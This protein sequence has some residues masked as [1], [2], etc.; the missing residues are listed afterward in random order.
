MRNPLYITLVLILLM[1]SSATSA[2][3]MIAQMK[4]EMKESTI[5]VCNNQAFLSCIGSSTKKCLSAANK[6]VSACEKLFPKS[7]TAMG[8]GNAFFAHASCMDKNIT[9]NLG[10][11]LEKLNRCD[12]EGAGDPTGNMAPPVAGMP[13]MGREQNIAMM[14][15]MLQ[16]HAQS[17]G[18]GGVTLPVYK[19]TTVM[20]HFANGEL[21]GM[22]QD[23]GIKPLP[24]LMLASPD[25]VNKIAKYYRGKLK[26]FR[27]HQIDNQIL[28]LKGGPKKYNDMKHMKI[29]VTT[30]HVRITPI[31]GIPGT[32]AG[33]RSQIEVAYKK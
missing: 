21:N 22:Y 20:S 25:S 24:A 23:M 4:Q 26:G 14:N 3:D 8:D 19:K 2:M 5:Q 15:Q 6:S 17:V 30:P 11:S 10:V 18:T 7:N 16:Q 12:P 32:P 28:F 27:E 31:Q 29:L 9:R 1:G 13:P 33:T